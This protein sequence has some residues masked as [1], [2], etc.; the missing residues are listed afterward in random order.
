MDP[1]RR[2]QERRTQERGRPGGR[3]GPAVRTGLPAVRPGLGVL[4]ALAV[5]VIVAI[6]FTRSAAPPPAA[7]TGPGITVNFASATAAAGPAVIGADGTRSVQGAAAEAELQSLGLQTPVGDIPDSDTASGAAGIVRH[8]SSAASDPVRTWMIT[9]R[10]GETAAA[11]SARFN[12]LYDAMKAAAPGIKVGGNVGQYSGAFLRTYLTDSGSRADFID[13]SFYGE[14]AAQQ[15]GSAGLLAALSTLSK[16]LSDAKSAIKAVVPARAADI[17]I[18]VGGWDITSGTDPVRF[19]MFA[20]MWDADLLGRMLAAGAGSLASGA[21]LLYAGGGGAPR[22]YQA[23]GPTPL[24]EAI[25]MFT[26]EGLFPRFGKATNAASSSLPGVDVFA[27][28]SP[29]EVIAVN[30]SGASRT[31]VLRVSAD[32]PL[33]A[34]QWRLGQANGAVEGPAAAGTATSRNGTFQLSLPSGSVTTIV[35]TADGTGNA[36]LTLA[37]ASTG[38]CLESGTE[39]GTESAGSVY[40]ARCAA[41]PHWR[42]EGTTLIDTRTGRCLASD[43]S[44]RV[45]TAACDGSVTQDWYN[46]GSRLVSEQT[47]RCLNANGTGQVYALSCT[48]ATQQNWT[49]AP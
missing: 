4:A 13:F 7:G 24:Y 15:A 9:A 12:V 32:T 11:Y 47:G 42:L 40:T 28:T 46:L 20:A 21:G 35:V 5:A 16:E 44:G 33:R 30:T 22:A 43:S 2:T 10:S 49:F 29:D 18:Y 25:A 48:G 37:N 45:S 27:S 23:G 26:G 8:A 39:S 14:G 6:W 17:A 38:Q 31:T 3:A 34:A 1:A 19:T 41:K 36:S